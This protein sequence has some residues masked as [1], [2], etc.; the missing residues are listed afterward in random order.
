M[1]Q[2]GVLKPFPLFPPPF[3][4]FFNNCWLLE[5]VA[6]PRLVYGFYYGFSENIIERLLNSLPGASV[7]APPGSN[8]IT[9]GPQP[10]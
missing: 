8:T 4:P 3:P 6:L 10:L 7:A 5:A 9:A 1:N 2:I